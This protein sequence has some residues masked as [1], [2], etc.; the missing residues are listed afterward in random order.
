LAGETLSREREREGG[1]R[2]RGG[3]QLGLASLLALPLTFTTIANILSRP[4]MAVYGL[5]RAQA[6]SDSDNDEE[7]KPCHG[8]RSNFL[9]WGSLGAVVFV[10]SNAHKHP[11]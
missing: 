11:A 4:T 3:Q 2:E 9:I 5:E 10:A 1:E 8:P 6:E 7:E